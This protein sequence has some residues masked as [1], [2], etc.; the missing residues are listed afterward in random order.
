[1]VFGIVKWV[2]SIVKR[3]LQAFSTAISH[4]TKPIAHGPVLGTIADLAR[5]KPQLVAENLLLRQ[6]LLVLKRSAKRPRFTAADRCL[7]VLL[8]SKL[9]NWKEAVLIVKPETILRW[10][11]QGFQLF[12]KRT[13]RATSRHPKIPME[14]ITLIKEMAANN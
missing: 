7:F 6:Q 2:Q 14:T 11:R 12:W 3:G 9:Q 10:H 8:A 13:S 5:S 4:V 1:M